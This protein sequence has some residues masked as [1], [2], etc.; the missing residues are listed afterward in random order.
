MVAVRF[1]RLRWNRPLIYLLGERCHICW[2]DKT[3]QKIKVPTFCLSFCSLFLSFFSVCQHKITHLPFPRR[4]IKIPVMECTEWFADLV[5]CPWGGEW[6]HRCLAAFRSLISL[7]P[8]L[9]LAVQEKKIKLIDNCSNMLYSQAIFA[10][11]MMCLSSCI[12]PN[13]MKQVNQ[14]LYSSF[15]RRAG[16]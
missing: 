16:P 13:S 10:R 9:L 11:L 7:S 4:F 5:F 3:E 6:C 2:H 8:W 12:V 1:R 14:E 15:K